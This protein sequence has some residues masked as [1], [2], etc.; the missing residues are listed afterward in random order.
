MDTIGSAFSLNKPLRLCSVKQGVFRLSLHCDVA[1]ADKSGR[2]SLSSLLSLQYLNID[3]LEVRSPKE[4]KW[5]CLSALNNFFPSIGT[6][7]GKLI[8]CLQTLGNVNVLAI[9]R[10]K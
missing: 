4:W 5:I 3:Y 6:V 9:D 8:V 7:Q 10:V 1:L 2:G